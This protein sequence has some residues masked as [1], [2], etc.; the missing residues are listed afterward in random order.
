M[1]I[2]QIEPVTSLSK[3]Y[4]AI[5]SKLDNG[6]VILAMRSR[7]TAVLLSVSDYEK[8]MTRLEHFELVAEA[9]RNLAKA[10]ANPSTVTSHDELKRMLLEKRTQER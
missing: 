2:P 7:P 4:R 9:K 6:P 3:D 10:D 8:L 5:F 1:H